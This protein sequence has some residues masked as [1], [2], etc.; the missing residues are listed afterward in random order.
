MP[1]L[2]QEL[3]Y[4]PAE[5]QDILSRLEEKDTIEGTADRIERLSTTI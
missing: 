5:V 2:Q 3:D 4:S 1:T